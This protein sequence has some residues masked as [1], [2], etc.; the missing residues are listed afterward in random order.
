MGASVPG[1]ICEHYVSSRGRTTL[2]VHHTSLYVLYSTATYT[3]VFRARKQNC[4]ATSH[5]KMCEL[6][7]RIARTCELSRMRILC[8]QNLI[9]FFSPYLLSNNRRALFSL[10]SISRTSFQLKISL[11]RLTVVEG[12]VRRE[13]PCRTKSHRIAVLCTSPYWLKPKFASSK[14]YN[15]ICF[16]T[17]THECGPAEYDSLPLWLIVVIYLCNKCSD[18]FTKILSNIG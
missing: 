15:S 3:P 14:I 16:L 11:V 12:M 9:C 18:S 8:S 10:R 17:V 7:L 4:D 13:K 6:P 1:E 5:R 2:L